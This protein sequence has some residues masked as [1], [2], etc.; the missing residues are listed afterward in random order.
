MPCE[1]PLWTQETLIDRIWS[2]QNSVLKII[3]SIST[4][5]NNH[6]KPS[7][8][9]RSQKRMLFCSKKQTFIFP[10]LANDLSR[11]HCFLYSLLIHLQ[12][13]QT[14]RTSRKTHKTHLFFQEYLTDLV[15]WILLGKGRRECKRVLFM[16]SSLQLEPDAI[17]EL[18]FPVRDSSNY[19]NDSLPLSLRGY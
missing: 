14:Y 9:L 16:V 18:L 6:Y 5:N 8:A 19:L 15:S 2:I 11:T 1:I 13:T 4:S 12:Y 17:Y 10:A 3:I 7:K